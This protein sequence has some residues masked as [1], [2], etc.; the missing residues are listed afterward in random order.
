M[1][2]MYLVAAVWISLALL[3]SL[4]SVRVGISVA[5]VEI[6]VGVLAGNLFTIPEPEWVAF[7]ASIGAVALTFL[8]GVDI[9]TEVLRNKLAATLLIGFLSFLLPFL[10]A[11][12]W[13]YGV[14]DWTGDA[15]LIAGI[16]LSTTSVAVVYAVMIETGLNR[17][18]LGKVILAACFVTDLGT[19]TA[20]GLLFAGF[21][22]ELV[23]FGA[24]TVAAL[25]VLPR[26]T[27]WF[28]RQYGERVSEPE[29]KYLFVV[30]FGLGAL[31]S[32]AGSEAV[33]PAYLVGLVLSDTFQ[34]R[35]ELA[36]RLR[37]IVF[38]LLTPFYF[39]R[40]GLFVS[41]GSLVAG[42]WTIVAF[43]AVKV[44]TKFAGVLPVTLAYGYTF[45]DGMYTT[46]MMSTGLTFGTI[47]SLYGLDN[48]LIT[49]QQ[50]S[51]LVTVVIA[52]AI[53]PTLVAQRF[54]LPLKEIKKVQ[55]EEDR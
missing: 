18:D 38:A 46:L 22:L 40:A 14:A 37:T 53:I 33:L 10:G 17:S 41:F 27:R 15:S 23:V 8:A 3:A 52:T 19:V 28:F 48:G 13:A 50:Y 4:V 16:A 44:A 39:I 20:L 54:F 1:E 11:A 30:L 25:L 31:A 49:Q 51:V 26:F 29:L 36:R 43:F 12:A 32:F 35:E 24:V 34:K 6:M 21:G 7:L 47:S 55:I 42:F 9:D 5:L 45:R 2:N